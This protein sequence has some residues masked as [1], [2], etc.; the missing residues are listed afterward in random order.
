MTALAAKRA[1]LIVGISTV[2]GVAAGRAPRRTDYIDGEVL[3]VSDDV[4]YGAG[5]VDSTV[6]EYRPGTEQR[7]LTD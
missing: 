6:D 3:D 2:G 1:P 7:R 4:T 5:D